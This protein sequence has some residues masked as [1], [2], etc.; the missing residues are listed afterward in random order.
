[1]TS[2]TRLTSYGSSA[3]QFF[4]TTEPAG[5]S[6]GTV[7][8]LHGGWWRD[9]HDLRQMD[10]LRDHLAD[11]GWR[12]H[13]LEYRRTGRDG[14]GWPQSLDDVVAGLRAMPAPVTGPFV[15]VGH[16]AGGHLALM[17]ASAVDVS[18]VVAL[19]PVTDLAAAL[20]DGLGEGATADFAPCRSG[21]ALRECSPVWRPPTTQQLLVHGTG[22]A[23]VPI[24]QSRAYFA[25][26]SAAALPVALHEVAGGDHFCV[27]DP[28]D[29][30]WG[31]TAGW[32]DG[33]EPRM[34]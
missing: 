9:V 5:P 28:A 26:A 1:M 2:V 33:L 6:R 18:A 16:S 19:A 15:L 25:A 34:R 29:P 3:S 24:A 7:V 4:E 12:V 23:R 32:M 13:N 22:D 20:R 8:T 17:A 30:S 21:D 31:P 10:P 27:I 14:G 11:R